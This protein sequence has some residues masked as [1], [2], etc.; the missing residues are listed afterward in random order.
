MGKQNIAVTADSVIFFRK[1][2]GEKVLLVQRGTNPFE[3][4]WALPG[5]FLKDDERLED[6]ARRELEE[7]TGLQVKNLHQLRVFDSPDRDPRGRTISIPFYGEVD[8]E[9]IVKGADDAAKAEWFDL[10]EL[11][12]LAFDHDQI[13]ELAVWKYKNKRKATDS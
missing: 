6:G 13:L 2:K 10:N 5:G 12:E 11:P 8:S 9:E 7:E 1:G 4:Q 3:G